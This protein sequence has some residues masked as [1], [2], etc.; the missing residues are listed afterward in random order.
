MDSY[1]FV[2]SPKGSVIISLF[3]NV[4]TT[5]VN[6]TVTFRCSAQGGPNNMFQWSKQGIVVY[7]G[8]QLELTMITGSDAGVY[9]CIVT[10]DAGSG[11]S[12]VS[13]IGMCYIAR[14][15]LPLL[16]KSISCITTFFY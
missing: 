4:L 10:N 15:Q 6:S 16:F 13:L 9:Q 14:M 12:S 8:S 11:D 1:I 7:N 3:G 2:V 5:S